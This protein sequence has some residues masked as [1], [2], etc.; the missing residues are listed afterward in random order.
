[1]KMKDEKTKKTY[2]SARSF[3]EQMYLVS[4]ERKEQ[5]RQDLYIKMNESVVVRV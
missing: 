5:E 3:N 1:M 4:K 2:F